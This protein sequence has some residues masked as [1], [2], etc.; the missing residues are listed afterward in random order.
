MAT[1][2]QAAGK[3][4]IV[5]AA[6]RLSRHR[7]PNRQTESGAKSKGC[8]S[9]GGTSCREAIAV[10]GAGCACG[11]ANMRSRACSR[12]LVHVRSG[13]ARLAAGAER[14]AAADRAASIG[15]SL[16][17][18][19]WAGWRGGR[20]MHVSAICASVRQVARKGMKGMH[21]S[22]FGAGKAQIALQYRSIGPQQPPPPAKHAENRVRPPA[23][24]R[25]ANKSV[26]SPSL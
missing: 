9:A 26:D 8:G 5:V 1:A 3:R 22:A 21:C 11:R 25:I 15:C 13:L 12:A 24:S 20:D 14:D 17:S 10:Q 6:S 16:L 19:G 23:A 4:H 18:A 2:C 7:D